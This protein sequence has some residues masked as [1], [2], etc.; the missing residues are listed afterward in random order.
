M[1]VF[2]LAIQFDNKGAV[3]AVQQ[4]RKVSD[5]AGKAQQTVAGVG[6]GASQAAAP[7]SSL[8]RQG[9]KAGA[10]I[11]AAMKD[12]AKNILA[13]VGAYKAVDAAMSFAK[14]GVEMNAS[15]EQS[16][17]GIASVI[18]SVNQ[19]EDAQGNLLS[20]A[21]AYQA[22]LSLAEQAM[23]RIKIMGLETIATTDDLVAGFQQLIGPAAA[24][25]LSMEQTLQFTTSMVQSLGAI[26]IPFNQLSAEARSLL[27][28][29]IVPTQDRLATTLGITG[30]MV[31]NWK[32]QGVL[33]EKLLE[34]MS[35]FAAA[36]DDVA[37]TWTGVKSNLQDAVDMVASMSSK[38]MYADLK[39]SLLT[40][41]GLLVDTSDTASGVGPDV[42]NIVDALGIVQDRIGG[43][44]L[45]GVQ[46]I[47]SAAKEFNDF[48]GDAGAVNFLDDLVTA[49]ETAAGAFV[50]LGIARKANLSEVSLKAPFD[51]AI[52]SVKNFKAA[53]VEAAQAELAEAKQAQAQYA[54]YLK[55]AEAQ[56]Y[57]A[58]STSNLNELRYTQKSVAERVAAAEKALAVAMNTST[59]AATRAGL[60]QKALTGVRNA[61]SGL[62]GLLGGPWG[63]ALTAAGAALAY[64]A[65]KETD[66]ERAARL[67]TEAEKAYQSAVKD[68]IDENGK[69]K[70][71]LTEVEKVR[72]EIARNKYEQEWTVR[73]R[74]VGRQIDNVIAVSKEANAAAA[75]LGDDLMPQDLRDAIPE[76]LLTTTEGLF[77]LFSRGQVTIEDFQTNLKTLRDIAIDG[78]YANSDY[79]KTLDDL[80]SSRTLD[81]LADKL[82]T[83]GSTVA[84]MAEQVRIAKKAMAGPWNIDSSNVE[85]FLKKTRE[86]IRDAQAEMA[87]LGSQKALAKLL[88]DIDVTQIAALKEAYGENGL[89]GAISSLG[90]AWD[91]MTI[92]QNVALENVLKMAHEEESVLKQLEKYRKGQKDAKSASSSAS[93]IEQYQIGLDRLKREIVALQASLDPALQGFDAMRAR[94]EAER[95]QA[96]AAAEAQEKLAVARK[97]ATPAQAAQTSNLEK[98]KAELE[99]QQKVRELE[100]KNLQERASF[101]KDL[102]EAYG[103]Y[104]LGLE[105]Q[106]QLLER[107]K[108]IWIAAGIPISDITR[109]L[110][111]QREELARD[112]WSG[113]TRGMRKWSADATNMA[114]QVE[115]SLTSAFDSASD[116]LADFVMTGKLDFAD[117]ANSIISDL[118]RIAARQA[119]GGIVGGIAGMFTGGG[120]FGGA[121]SGLTSFIPGAGF[122]GAASGL[123]NMIP[124]VSF[125][126]HGNVFSA[127]GLSAHSNTVVDEPTFFGYD[128]HFTAFASGAGLM[129]EAGPEA[130]MPLS[131]MSGGDLGVKVMWPDDMMRRVVEMDAWKA[132]VGYSQEM[133]QAIA[134]MNEMRAERAA[135][136]AGAPKVNVTIINQA[137][138]EV[139]TSQQTNSDGGIDLKIMMLKEVARDT[140]RRGGFNN[141]VL[142]NQFGASKRPIKY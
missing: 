36:G 58:R 124:G 3:T 65:G 46:S 14:R 97:Q 26:G 5:A 54:A 27:D 10:E 44:I 85:G 53:L 133:M 11:S 69:L 20:G 88:P 98:Q 110:E 16:K 134:K 101:Y 114:Q 21:D 12:A 118:A 106:N 111:L 17:I 66:A 29:T 139:E 9:Q 96:I 84:G 72:V 127:P 105:Y 35:A 23:N 128:R 104:N 86:S 136:M 109:M 138:A 7:M 83:V 40:I 123:G 2:N 18:A 119:I 82:R 37:K 95:D 126:A 131:R 4:L 6:S 92:E 50:A 90:N 120:S 80:L 33:A 78:G 49:L 135:A 19:L 99:Y 71:S 41:Q 108:E 47:V 100:E 39:E 137:G 89:E 43:T 1:P 70:R 79:V 113:F 73:V 31:R 74:E 13:L 87:G 94:L 130:V 125:S 60:A 67:H 75:A 8:G 63:V 28:G 42:K 103:Q 48:I 91:E 34:K 129:G 55:T 77:S 102:S 64:L 24:A 116:A 45:S 141:K 52:S 93:R 140:A 76:E 22:A 57:A 112:P 61:F 15:W 38:G 115:T 59:A 25:G 30:D 62:L 56:R 32:E 107:Q 117:L 68:A 51:A 132:N 81:E 122:G 121:A 142:R